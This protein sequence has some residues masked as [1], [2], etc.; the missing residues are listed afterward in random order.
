RSRR[1]RRRSRARS[2][3]GAVRPTGEAPD[4]ARLQT[5]LAR[6]GSRDA[7]RVRRGRFSDPRGT[8]AAPRTEPVQGWS[9]LAHSVASRARGGGGR[10]AP[11]RL[12]RGPR[13]IC[14]WT[15]EVAH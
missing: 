2:I 10:P 8:V 5:T 3:Y 11:V 1:R 4:T 15:Q 7:R 13:R 14:S 9:D 12:A 6:S